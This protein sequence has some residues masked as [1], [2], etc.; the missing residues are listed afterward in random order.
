VKHSVQTTGKVL[1][2]LGGIW[3]L[4]VLNLQG[5]DSQNYLGKF[6]R[7]FVTLGLEILR[8]FRLKILFEA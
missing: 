2:Q 6:I 8:L 4:K 5:G 7:F 3:Y 1:K